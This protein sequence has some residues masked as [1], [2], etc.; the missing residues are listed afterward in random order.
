MCTETS[1]AQE[2]PGLCA[3]NVVEEGARLLPPR[4]RAGCRGT[5]SRACS[6]EDIS[7]PRPWAPELRLP[8]AVLPS[9]PQ[10]TVMEGVFGA[11]AFIPQRACCVRT[12]SCSSDDCPPASL[13]LGSDLRAGLKSTQE[14]VYRERLRPI[15]W[16]DRG[17][18]RPR[19]SPGGHRE[20]TA[21]RH[22]AS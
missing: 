1:V 10:T 21:E 20:H 4:S 18:A 16:P 3:V 5:E 15:S 12:T 6:C 17:R 8:A 2:A 14:G 22:G 19:R 7:N 13:C 9:Q 11:R